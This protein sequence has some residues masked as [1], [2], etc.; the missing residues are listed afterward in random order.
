MKEPNWAPIRLAASTRLSGRL[1]SKMTASSERSI[2]TTRRLRLGLAAAAAVPASTAGSS[3]CKRRVAS[4]RSI[5]PSFAIVRIS[6]RALLVFMQPQAQYSVVNV[7]HILPGASGCRAQLLPGEIAIPRGHIALRS[8]PS[9]GALTGVFVIA[10]LRSTTH[11]SLQGTTHY[12]SVI[13][14]LRSNLSFWFAS[15]VQPR[16]PRYARP[17]TVIASLRSNLSFWFASP[18]QPRS[19]RYARPPTV[20]ASLRSNL[21]F[22]LA[23]PEQSRSP[24]FAR[25]DKTQERSPRC[26]RDDSTQERSPSYARDDRTRER[27]PSYARDDKKC[28]RDDR[29]QERSPRSARDDKNS[30]LR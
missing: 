29:T 26:A 25:D 5:F 4:E 8:R 20:I 7:T 14:S 30:C 12:S 6:I 21:S 2:L 24:R 10:S 9:K 3:A 23:S 1:K 16:S 15:P 18:G 17:P 13:A 27:S 11:L 28:A 22:W 19:P